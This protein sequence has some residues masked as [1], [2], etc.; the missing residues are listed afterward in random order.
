MKK[1]RL[2]PLLVLSSF[3]LAGCASSK[4]S[5]LDSENNYDSDVINEI[6]DD[7]V[8]NDYDEGYEKDGDIELP[9]IY[10][11]LPEGN[12]ITEG[13]KY[14][15]SGV[16]PAVNITAGKSD[17]VYL[18]FDGVSISSS[19]GIALSNGK[20]ELYIILLNG[21]SNSISNDFL[22]TNALHSKG[23]THIQGSGSLSITSAQK[24]A[25]KTS[26]D[27]F[28]SD[29]SLTVNGAAHGIAAQ[30]LTCDG[31]T[32]NATAVK[33]GIQTECDSATQSFVSTEGFVK[34]INTKYTSSTT[35]DGIQAD[36]FIY[37]SGGEYSI[38]TEGSFVPYSSANKAEY[39]L[40]D[41]DFKYVKSGNSYKRVAKDEI[42]SLSSS[43]YALAN[44]VKGLKAGIIEY[45]SDDDDV[46]DG[47][48]TTGD[49]D[50]YIAHGAKLS[51]DSTDDCVHTNYGD[52]NLAAANLTLDTFDDGVHADYTLNVNNASIQVNSSYEGLE[53]ANVVVDGKDTTIVANSSD[54]GINAASDLVDENNITIKDGYLRV[55]ASGDGLDANSSLTFEGGTTIVEGPG[56][57][58]GS[59]DAEQINFNG[60][61]VFACS[62]SGMTESMSASQY[63]FAY[64]G[65][66]MSA[67]KQITI[68]DPDGE[69]LF[70]YTLK[71]S[72]NQII[73][74]HPD[75][76]NG[77]KYTIYADSS[78]IVTI[79]LSGT[80]TKQGV[81]G[82]G[83]GPGGGG[84]GGW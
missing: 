64:Q 5:E 56:A 14:Y 32:I 9:D 34:M 82:G 27:L 48:V 25:L 65:S 45:D 51:I 80:L 83:G 69:N 44:S 37:I 75:M 67:G 21:S 54:D 28:I 18:F 42:H 63:T 66:S 19:E 31:A 40:E 7:G 61:I 68:Q 77:K 12:A 23:K 74:S 46:D 11:A 57:G 3:M 76:E 22:D 43:Y 71:Q 16:Q 33:D 73:F 52:V 39:G 30:T 17:V 60:G 4:G 62:Q 13:G 20:A 47:S 8:S 41:D 72:C 29:I 53:G 24:T 49:Y 10:D 58:N 6:S 79:T 81:S 35:G 50:I 84:H 78:S 59:L 38:K 2:L 15:L 70:Q 1:T 55:Y 36:T 26:K